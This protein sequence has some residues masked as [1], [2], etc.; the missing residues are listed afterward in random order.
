MSQLDVIEKFD[1]TFAKK[2]DEK[3][4]ATV[5]GYD[6]MHEMALSLMQNSMGIRAQV[7]V[8]GAGCG[9]ELLTMGAANREWTF[10]GVDPAEKMLEIARH[11]VETSNISNRVKL[12][13]GMVSTLPSVPVFDGAT[14][15]LVMHFLD[16]HEGKPAFL[17]SLAERL[18]PGSPLVLVDL[19]RSR[20]SKEFSRL[21][22]AWLN[23]LSRRGYDI[24]GHDK[25]MEMIHFVS[26]TRMKQL[27][28]D[29]GFV[30]V[31]QFYGAFLFGGW[32][33]TRK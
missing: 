16:D 20:D 28:L 31:S 24:S 6:E 19:Y 21:Y 18:R 23:Y 17:R 33:A 25:E 14:A 13:Q 32:V 27:L 29:A 2:Y 8:A 10:V 1:L 30:D 5:P 9:M 26:D 12:I 7:L 15:I 22:A 11:R 4:R 3:V